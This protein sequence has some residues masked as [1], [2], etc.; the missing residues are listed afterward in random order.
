ML[1]LSKIINIYNNTTKMNQS[2]LKKIIREEVE[3]AIHMSTPTPTSEGIEDPQA[4]GTNIRGIISRS[5][6]SSDVMDMINQYLNDVGL[7][8]LRDLNTSQ[9]YELL[10]KISGKA[11]Q[12]MKSEPSLDPRQDWSSRGKYRS[13]SS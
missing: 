12:E 1:D 8:N 6:D 13:P 9:S 7:S 2:E 4:R 3:K 11:S 5:K 10:S